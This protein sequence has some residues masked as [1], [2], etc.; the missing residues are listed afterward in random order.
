MRFF[1][2]VIVF[3]E[4]DVFAAPGL[5]DVLAGCDVVAG[6]DVESKPLERELDLECTTVTSRR[7]TSP[8][9]PESVCELAVCGD[10]CAGARSGDDVMAEGGSG[11]GRFLR[12]GFAGM[13]DAR[14]DA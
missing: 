14:D 13:F 1:D 9:T 8:S 2:F 10:T 3:C 12:G 4:C 7:S 11:A 5:S 6:D